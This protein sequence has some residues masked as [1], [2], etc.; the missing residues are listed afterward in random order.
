[1][2]AEK[3]LSFIESAINQEDKAS[4]DTFNTF[5]KWAAESGAT[6]DKPAASL[7]PKIYALAVIYTEAKK[8]YNNELAKSAGRLD[9]KKAAERM[10][11][12]LRQGR[13]SNAGKFKTP[14]GKYIYCS[15][16]HG[17]RITDAFDLPDWQGVPP[18]GIIKCFDTYAQN[19]GERVTPPTVAELKNIIRQTKAENKGKSKY[20]KTPAR[21]DFGEGLPMVDAQRLL[22]ILESL[23]DVTITTA[24]GNPMV[25]GIYCQSD[26]GDAILMPIK[27]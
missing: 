12:E 3:I 24:A 6:I 26:I 23:G 9:A 22:D 15:G 11:T 7:D 25:S 19:N 5:C 18:E 8:E 27:K 20:A 14:D 21:Y 2:K 4:R 10:I 16:Y 17:I 13:R 1:M